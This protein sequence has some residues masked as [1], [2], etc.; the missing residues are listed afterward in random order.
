MMIIMDSLV[1]ATMMRES[2][3]FVFVRKFGKI[4]N[5]SGPWSEVRSEPLVKEELSNSFLCKSITIF[6][7]VVTFVFRYGTAD[8]SLNLC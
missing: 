2:N 5:C 3:W 1:V 4:L 8:T 6:K 7:L